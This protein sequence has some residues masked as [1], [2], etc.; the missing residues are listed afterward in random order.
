MW[1]TLTDGLDYLQAQNLAGIIALFWF[2]II[3]EVP[4]YTLTFIAAALF[5]KTSDETEIDEKTLGRVTVMIAG[6]NEEDAIERCVY[7]LWEQSL[8]PDEI[9]V[10]SDGSTDRMTAKLND[11][12]R[13][14]LIHKA[15]GTELRSGKSA[16]VNLAERLSSGDILINVDCDCSFDRHALRQIVRPFA[17][18]RIGAVS[19]NIFLRNATAS[20]ISSFQA[21]EYLISISLGKQALNLIDQVSCASGAFSAFR[22][23]ALNQI[24]G[25]DSGGGEDLDVTLRL[26]RAGWK[27][28]FAADAICYTDV[29]ETLSAFVR[30][31]FRWER[32][33]VRLRFRKHVDFINPFSDRFKTIELLHEA[34]FLLFNVAAS[35]A[36]PFYILWLFVTYGD[37]AFVI[38]LAAQMALL[39]IDL[40]TF[41]LAA[42]ATPKAKVA[43]FL[44]F[45]FGYSIFN[46]LFMRFIRVAAYVQEWV[47]EASYKDSYVP[48]KVHQVRE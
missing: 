7:S 17:D 43:R 24:G 44:P 9:I 29:P 10:I 13:S 16:A 19:G 8:Q 5:P 28:E 41:F 36:L 26:R 14:G 46:S 39:A 2:V 21:I 22:K 1:T 3:F 31:R 12:L 34:E 30:Q 42:Y 6:H 23:A 38:L 27:I 20:L 48:D 40:T 18:P 33:A 35:F 25:L 4:R 37:L 11:L 45:I 15:H 32:D 47:F